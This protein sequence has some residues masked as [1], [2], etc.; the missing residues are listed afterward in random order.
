MSQRR[1]TR[2]LTALA[3]CLAFP[4]TGASVTHAADITSTAGVCTVRHTPAETESG[5]ALAGV[6]AANWSAEILRDVPSV[7]EDMALARTWHADKTGDQLADMPDDVRAALERINAASARAG[8]RDGEATAPLRILVERNNHRAAGHDSYT[9]TAT[10]ARGRLAV[11]RR[12]GATTLLS[13]T[14][15]GLSVAADE[16]WKRAWER[17][18]GAQAE[19]A[20][21]LAELRMCASGASGP[22][23]RG[24]ASATPV[25]S[26]DPRQPSSAVP[27][28]GVPLGSIH[29]SLVVALLEDAGSLKGLFH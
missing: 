8:Y 3:A 9:M 27:G 2:A 5:L 11:A 14:R 25:R 23:D 24:D 22:A 20:A 18:P 15:E 21:F 29:S 13:G 6:F 28:G 17:T 19:E 4:L 26:S 1:I 7:A 12:T 16:A 10:E